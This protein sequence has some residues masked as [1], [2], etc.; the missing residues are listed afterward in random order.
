MDPTRPNPRAGNLPGAYVFAGQNG[1]GSR[2]TTNSETYMKAWGPRIGIAY[3]VAEHMVIRTA[4]GISYSPGGGLSLSG[5]NVTQATDGYSG[6]ANFQT[7]NQGVTPAFN[8]N[9]GFPQNFDRPPFLDPGLNVGGGTSMW[10][11]KAYIPMQRQDWNFGT[12]FQIERTLLDI[13]YVGAKS[14]R[15]NTGAFN[16]NQVDPKYLSLGALLQKDIAD[17]DVAAAGFRA[18]YAGFT[19][20]LAQAL[21]PFP[22]YLNVG[23]NNTANVGNSTYHSLQAKVERQFSSGLFLLSTYTWSKSITDANSALGSFFSPAARD[24]YNRGLEK[25]LSVFDSPHR[26]VTA[27]TYELPFGPGKAIGN[28]GGVTGKLIGGWQVNGILTYASAPPLQVSANNTLPLFNSG[29]T[30]D[31]VL[32]VDPKVNNPSF[33]P[34]R[35]LY[36]DIKAFSVPAPGAIGT[37]PIVLPHTRGFFRLNEDFGILKRTSITESVNIEFRF[38]M[39]NL[40]NRAIFG[41]P[42]AN[43]NSSNFGRVTSQLPAPRNGQFAL[44]VNF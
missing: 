17:P 12:Q 13:S 4:Y 10:G 32:G 11:D 18:P 9:S 23:L 15:L 3:R 22:Q 30:P 38:E 19:G 43:I 28:V 8:W 27:F 29:N 35:D 33:D 26:F 36:L 6:T 34:N 31:S 42:D 2:L 24:H 40:F 25:A 20:S 39:F 37:S 44:K 21:R 14:T 16:P 5:G 1:V 41:P 7:S